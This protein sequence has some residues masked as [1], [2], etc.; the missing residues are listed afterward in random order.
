MAGKAPDSPMSS[1]RAQTRARLLQATLE[2]LREKGINQVSLDGVGARVGVTKG[3]IYDNFASKDAMILAA[4]ASLP[5]GQGLFPWPTGRDG[6]VRQRLRRLGE[7]VLGGG[8]GTF[9]AGH[10]DFLLYALTHE[11]MRRRMATSGAFLPLGGEAQVLALFASEELPT[12][13]AVFAVML[14]A[15]IPGLLYSR[16]LSSTDD[17]TILSIF[18]SLAGR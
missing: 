18:E 14:N 8:A 9:S 5:Q 17:E 7:A 16:M 13:P 2:L 6:T 15:L 1:R 10:A 12:P 3:A 11:D 4:L